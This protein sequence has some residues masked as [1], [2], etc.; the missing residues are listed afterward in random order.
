MT[1]NGKDWMEAI[2]EDYDEAQKQESAWRVKAKDLLALIKDSIQKR[3]SSTV[4]RKLNALCEKHSVSDKRYWS[5]I[6]YRISDGMSGSTTP[7]KIYPGVF[8]EFLLYIHEDDEVC[9]DEIHTHFKISEM[10]TALDRIG[11]MMEA[12]VKEGG[13]E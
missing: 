1:V 12:A 8:V 3:Y 13:V 6:N 2:I 7:P 4:S 5:V 9:R 11:R 10:D